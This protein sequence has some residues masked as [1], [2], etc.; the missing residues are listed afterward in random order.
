M[1]HAFMSATPLPGNNESASAE[2]GRGSKI[3]NASKATALKRARCVASDAAFAA[4]LTKALPAV[5]S[6]NVR[7]SI[8]HLSYAGQH[9]ST[10]HSA[11]RSESHRDLRRYG[12]GHPNMD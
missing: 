5:S 9:C 1:R 7:R 4:L 6:K 12:L 10:H 11:T 2:T 3:G 8:I